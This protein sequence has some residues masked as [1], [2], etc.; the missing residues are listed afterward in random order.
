MIPQVSPEFSVETLLHLVIKLSPN[1]LTHITG[2]TDFLASNNAEAVTTHVNEHP[3]LKIVDQFCKTYWLTEPTRTALYCS[4]T[5]PTP[6][7]PF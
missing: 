7:C 6:S 4:E 2:W 1:Q 3:K 5:W